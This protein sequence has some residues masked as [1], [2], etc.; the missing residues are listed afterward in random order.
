MIVRA[1]NRCFNEENMTFDQVMA[2]LEVNLLRQALQQSA[3]NRTKA[4]RALGLSLS[5][6]RDKLKKHNLE[7]EFPHSPDGKPHAE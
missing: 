3:G 6:L 4:A 2:C 1:C 5:T 7:E